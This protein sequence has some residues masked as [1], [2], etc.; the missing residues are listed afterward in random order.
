[1][2]FAEFNNNK[3]NNKGLLFIQNGNLYYNEFDNGKLN[4]T[5]LKFD[6]ISN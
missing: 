2:F 6:D 1:M 3:A 4:G 5:Q